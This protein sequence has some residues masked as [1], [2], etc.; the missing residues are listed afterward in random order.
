MTTSIATETYVPRRKAARLTPPLGPQPQP[1]L[2]TATLPLTTSESVSSTP[3][4]SP[5]LSTASSSSVDNAHVRLDGSSPRSGTGNASSN[6]HGHL[7]RLARE[8]RTI[9]ERKLYTPT[10]DKLVLVMVGLPARG[11]SFIAKKLWKFLCWKGL[12]CEVFNVGQLRRTL[13]AGT[14]DHTFFDP[15]N[16]RAKEER[17]QLAMQSLQQV[18]DWFIT[19]GGGE[20]GGDVAVFDATNT[21]KHRRKTL[22]DTFDA[23]AK[24]NKMSVHVV[25]VESI[26]TNEAVIN[27]NITQKVT[28]SPDYRH[29]SVEEAI[30]DLKQRMKNYEAAYEALEDGEGVS[31][32]KLFDLQSKVHAKGMY[33]SL[34]G[35]L[36]P[37]CSEN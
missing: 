8:T 30:E 7:K 26:C 6:P 19:G 14:Q 28:S 27:A 12:K 10:A 3:L 29:M 34:F 16:T 15:N 5:A 36:I 25:F 20:K 23:F 11:K 9:S 1:Q 21:T 2:R 4:A 24:A 13:C 33:V 17:E 18:Q 35:C 32:I 31:Y 22:L 37:M